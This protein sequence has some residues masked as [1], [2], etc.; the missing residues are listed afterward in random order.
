MQVVGSTVYRGVSGAKVAWWAF[1]PDQ[2]ISAWHCR[3]CNL[4]STR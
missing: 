4:A 1:G 2:V 3:L